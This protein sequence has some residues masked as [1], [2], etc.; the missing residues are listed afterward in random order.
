MNEYMT[1]EATTWPVYS[2]ITF[3][4]LE[5]TGFYGVYNASRIEPLIWGIDMGCPFATENCDLWPDTTTDMGYRCD[6]DS[7]ITQCTFDFKSI[8]TC[9][10]QSP[11]ELADYCTYY[12]DT[13]TQRCDNNEVT[14]STIN[15]NAGDFR[16]SD[17][18]CIIST[19]LSINENL[20]AINV[21]Q[22]A[23]FR[24]YKMTCRSETELKV[25]VP[26]L[27]NF[28]YYDCPLT[29]G[30]IDNVIGFGGAITC[31]QGMSL[32]ICQDVEPDYSWPSITTL[33]PT[34]I[35]PASTITI[36]GTN[37]TD[38]MTVIIRDYCTTVTV[39]SSTKLTAVLPPQAAWSSLSDLFQ[40]QE[41]VIVID[42]QNRTAFLYQGL[43]IQLDTGASIIRF[44]QANPVWA[45][46]II[47]GFVLIVVLLICCCY[48]CCCKPSAKLR[49]TKTPR[50]HVSVTEDD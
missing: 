42:S 5:D 41:S 31:A 15:L 14:P 21:P 45:A 26:L 25:G 13:P 23:A 32:A 50:L 10:Y 47:G 33:I 19:L 16:S 24:C 48:H 22:P 28:V 12:V 8:G 17:S 29:G 20:D 1:G 37:F 6:G 3:G 30:D 2:N 44:I 39:S 9:N 36:Q 34:S 43:Q 46:L 35:T 27:A 11:D 18:R 4:L 49:K 7:P 40:R 38:P